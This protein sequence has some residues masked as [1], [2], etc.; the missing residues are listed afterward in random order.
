MFK[1]RL[2]VTKQNLLPSPPPKAEW[3]LSYLVQGNPTFLQ[4]N[5]KLL[6]KNSEVAYCY[7]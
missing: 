3:F 4:I 5:K 1:Y 7:L 6:I 2:E